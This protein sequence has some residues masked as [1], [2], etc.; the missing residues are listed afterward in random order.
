MVVCPVSINTNNNLNFGS[1]NNPV[2]PFKV[3]T[4]YGT[5]AVSEVDYSKDLTPK[6]IRK[7]TRFFL[8]NFSDKTN[9]G[10]RLQYRYGTPEEKSEYLEMFVK[11]YT[12][13]FNDETLQ[14][15]L[16]LLVAKDKKGRIQGACLTH[17]N[18]EIPDSYNTTLYVNSI[19]TNEK[20]R[21]NDLA[22]LMLEKSLDANKTTFTDVYLTSANASNPFYEKLGFVKLNP[23]N[24]YEKVILSYVEQ[25]RRDYPEFVTP[26]HKPLQPNR[27][28]WYRMCADRLIFWI[29]VE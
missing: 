9:D 17:A 28:R 11:L 26:Y 13:I 19:A 3:A 16:T 8:Y 2:K 18:L 23:N 12:R 24:F 27:P 21:G 20:Y 25:T 14:P 29:P 22:K 10:V 5:L 15:D 6:F 1:I 7:L 4:K